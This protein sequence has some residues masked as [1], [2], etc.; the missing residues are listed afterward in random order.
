MSA[1]KSSYSGDYADIYEQLEGFVYFLANRNQDPDM[2]ASMEFD[3]LVG[4]L[5]LELVKGIEYYRGVPKERMIKLLKRM[6]D[7]RIGELRYRYYLTHRGKG[8]MALSLSISVD[9][10]GEDSDF[11]ELIPDDVDVE[12]QCES[13]ERVKLT[14]MR[15]SDTARKVF[16]ALI[17]GN[18]RL[19]MLTATSAKR[20]TNK[21]QDRDV[22]DNV[23]RPWHLADALFMS[24]VEVRAALVEIRTAYQQ[25][26]E[27]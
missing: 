27:E 23:V 8:R 22:P 15:L 18:K 17:F 9:D 3:E 4:E 24:E 1:S 19:S 11:S 25:V 10:N 12:T 2:P 13:H 16:D 26:M 20:A 7:N 5:F 6:L 14:R 21:Y